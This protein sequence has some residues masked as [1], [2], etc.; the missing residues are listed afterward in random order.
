[1]RISDAGVAGV[2]PELEACLFSACMAGDCVTEPGLGGGPI[3]SSG[4]G[5]IESAS[6]LSRLRRGSNP[7]EE[8]RFP[9]TSS[10]RSVTS[11]GGMRDDTVA[12]RRPGFTI[13]DCRTREAAERGAVLLLALLNFLPCSCCPAPDSSNNSMS[14]SIG[15]A[16]VE[17]PDVVP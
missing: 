16:P 12:F 3:S 5:E 17:L 4:S 8:G 1:M 9:R 11:F 15:D 14:T 7:L 2:T 10:N 13:G 6:E